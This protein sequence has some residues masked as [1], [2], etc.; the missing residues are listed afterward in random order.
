V[1]RDRRLQ[2]KAIPV[3]VMIVGL[4]SIALYAVAAAAWIHYDRRKDTSAGTGSEGRR[5]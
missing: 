3:N 5:P 2:R 4:L 1:R